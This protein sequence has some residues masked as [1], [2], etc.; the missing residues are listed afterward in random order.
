MQFRDVIRVR[1]FIRGIGVPLP[2]VEIG[3]PV[4]VGVL[5]ENVGVFNR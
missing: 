5:I 1:I 2:L 4:F 3:E